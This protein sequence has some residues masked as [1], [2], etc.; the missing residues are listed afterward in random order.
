M[1]LLAFYT[2][3]LQLELD[4]IDDKELIGDIQF[5]LNRIGYPLKVDGVVGPKTEAAF[6]RFKKDHY[7][8]DA[9]KIGPA[10]AKL[11]LENPDNASELFRP[12]DGI[13]WVSSPF[14]P[15]SLGYHKGID[16]AANEG[17]MVYAVAAG[18]ITGAVSGC[19]VGNF[20]C[21]GGYGNCVYI[22]HVGLPFTQTRYAHLT[23]LAQG[24]KVGVDVKK[25]QLIGYVGNTGHS[26]GNHLHFETRV[27]GKA[28]N[29]IEF[30]NPVV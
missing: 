16:I 8:G 19:F 7:L 21:G 30:I 15:R 18:R 5:H 14:G 24:M 17:T 25:G 27:N 22:D 11:L 2:S 13:G 1:N 12:T 9:T 29:P 4:T 3:G 10:S 6:A 20:R 23:R 28:R 26:F